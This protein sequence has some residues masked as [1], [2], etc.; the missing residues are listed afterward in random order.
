[1]VVDGGS[2]LRWVKVVVG[3]DGCLWVMDDGGSGV[4]WGGCLWVVDDS[5]SGLLRLIIIFILLVCLYYFN[6]VDVKIKV[7]ILNVL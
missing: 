4:G 6:E 3:C 5:G 2:G 7:L 1:M